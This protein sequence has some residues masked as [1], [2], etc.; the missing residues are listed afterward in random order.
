MRAPSNSRNAER[1]FTL[2]EMLI[3]TAIILVGLVAVAQL[4]PASALLNANNRSDGTA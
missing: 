2:T 3:A 4:V 1:G